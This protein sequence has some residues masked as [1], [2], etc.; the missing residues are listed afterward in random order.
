VK[1]SRAL[2]LIAILALTCNAHAGSLNVTVKDA[3]GSLVS[4]A[5]VIAKRDGAKLERPSNQ[6][7]IDQRDKQFVPYVTAVQ[8]GT[9]IAFP[10]KDQIRH[11]VYSLS[12][13]KKFELPLYAGSPAAP[14]LF[15]KEGFVTLGCNIHDWMIAYVAV[16]ATP[17]FE[18]TGKDGRAAMK[19]L[20]PGK[21]T[22][23][24]WQPLLKGAPEQLAQHVDL[25]ANGGKDLVFNLE[26]KP[27]FRAKRAPGLSTG[28]YP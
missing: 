19:D 16:V 2:T 24:A 5:V 1:R 14:V 23:E 18:V 13:A 12:P 15:D 21:Y 11:H 3:K 27:D 8:V 9:S 17:Y 4:N 20:P 26:L 7:I 25:T 6:A 22:V 28:G 10:N